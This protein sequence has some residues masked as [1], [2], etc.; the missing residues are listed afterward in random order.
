V[1][2]VNLTDSPTFL[3]S[4]FALASATPRVQPH[5]DWLRPEYDLNGRELALAVLGP[6]DALAPPIGGPRRLN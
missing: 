2:G 1:P 4:P 3:D 6:L 5:L